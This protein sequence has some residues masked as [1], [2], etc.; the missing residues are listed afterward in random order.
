[1]SKAKTPF[2]WDNPYALRAQLTDDECVVQHAVEAYRQGKLLP[3]VRQAFCHEQADPAIFR[4]MGELG[5]LGSTMPEQYGG[6]GPAYVGYG[7]IA[8]EVERVDCG[9]RSMMSV[10]SS[11]VIEP[12]EVADALRWLCRDGAASVTGQRISVSGGEVA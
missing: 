3:R 2:S 5:V 7:L 8:R 9:Y 11:L 4:E 1:M 10:Q 12:G 6:T